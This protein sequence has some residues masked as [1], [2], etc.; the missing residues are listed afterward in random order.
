MGVMICGLVNRVFAA[1]PP[2][3][4]HMFDGEMT[5]GQCMSIIKRQSLHITWILRGASWAMMFFG[6]L[7]LFGPVLLIPELIPFIGGMIA[8]FA[9]FIIGVI[10]FI[11]T[12]FIA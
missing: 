12:M 11:L 6:T 3:I 5:A 7:L 9:S 2:Q 1:A 10:A 4:Y 8:R